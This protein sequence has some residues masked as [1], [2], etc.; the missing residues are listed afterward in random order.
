MKAHLQRLRAEIASDR[1]ALARRLGELR[2]LD[3]GGAPDA[4]QLA[5]AAVAL[6]HAYSAVETIFKRVAQTLE[7]D[8]PR[9]AD[10]HQ[11][12]LDEM[13]LELEGIRPVV[14]SAASHQLLRRL[15]AFRHFFRHAYAVELD[16]R[17]LEAVRKD[18]LEA[19]PLVD[20]DLDQLDTYLAELVA[21][22]DER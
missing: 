6:H 4:G 10:W 3:L 16:A 12:L 21:R 19:A 9:G 11:V 14:L 22:A 17:R 20:A 7:Q 2:G 13:A 18:A 8:V 5:R 15:L 1:D